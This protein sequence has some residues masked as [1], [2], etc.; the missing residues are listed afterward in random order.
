MHFRIVLTD[1]CHKK[2]IKKNEHGKS[3]MFFIAFCN[4]LIVRCEI[5]M[6]LSRV[7]EVLV[8]RKTCIY[9]YSSLY[10]S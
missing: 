6:K 4:K 5:G 10:V 9:V 1:V 2:A 8:K 7:F 3:D